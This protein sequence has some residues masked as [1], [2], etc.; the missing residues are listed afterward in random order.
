MASAASSDGRGAS[1]DRR[2]SKRRR[3]RRR[4]ADAADAARP[5]FAHAYPQSDELGVLLA[6]FE[7]GDFAQVR[8]GAARLAQSADD[9]A[10]RR[11]ARDLGRRIEPDRLSIVL[12]GLG[13]ALLAALSVYY[14][15]R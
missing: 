10:V 2:R 12:L 7:R 9:E 6:A 11:A 15:T 1:T 13:V 8:Q 5:A 3:K 4:A 14:L